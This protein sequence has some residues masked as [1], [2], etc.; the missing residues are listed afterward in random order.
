MPRGAK[1]NTKK[2]TA[3]KETESKTD[4]PGSSSGDQTPTTPPRSNSSGSK[5][6]SPKK[7]GDPINPFI[8]NASDGEFDAWFNG[9]FDIILTED[10]T[11]ELA[12]DI[13]SM[14]DAAYEVVKTNTNTANQDKKTIEHRFVRIGVAIGNLDGFQVHLI[15]NRLAA[16]INWTAMTAPMW[17]KV[18][19]LGILTQMMLFTSVKSKESD[20]AQKRADRISKNRK[21]FY[22]EKLEKAQDLFLF[23]SALEI[24]CKRV[25]HWDTVVTFTDP[26][27]Q[28]RKLYNYREWMNHETTIHTLPTYNWPSSKKLDEG[29][30]TLYMSVWASLSKSLQH[31]MSTFKKDM[32]FNGSKLIARIIEALRPEISVLRTRSMD[33]VT[34]FEKTVVKEEWDLLKVLPDLADHVRVLITVGD[35]LDLVYTNVYGTLCKCTDAQFNHDVM[36]WNTK[37]QGVSSKSGDKIL[38]FLKACVG[39]VHD[40]IRKGSWTL[41]TPSTYKKTAPTKKRKSDDADLAL[42]SFPADKKSKSTDDAKE[43]KALRV[44][45]KQQLNQNKQLKA[46]LAKSKGT[47]RYGKDG[48]LLRPRDRDR[49]NKHKKG[50]GNNFDPFGDDQYGP[51]A[52]CKTLDDWNGFIKGTNHNTETAKTGVNVT[53]NKGHIQK[54]FWCS[55]CNKMGS[56]DDAHCKRRKSNQTR[57]DGADLELRAQAASLQLNQEAESEEE[58][59]SDSRPLGSYSEDEGDE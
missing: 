55:N 45:L 32:N 27:K 5:V 20:S 15:Y 11:I 49:T 42:S 3:P 37:H 29:Y 51:H 26:Q 56:H 34:S 33:Y 10:Q 46:N 19:C 17:Y 59:H 44:E 48:K 28:E 52:T 23:L 14:L 21:P 16:S 57:S 39:F 13:G 54:W 36:H 31:E 24:E 2:E 30:L 41:A 9:S 25:P 4:D 1:R 6:K 35:T 38:N 12:D 47:Q 7:G 53:N 43:L 40:S 18:R 8:Y 22:P 58:E 50:S